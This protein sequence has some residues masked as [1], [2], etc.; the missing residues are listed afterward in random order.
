MSLQKNMKYLDCARVRGFLTWN[1]ER[2]E[3]IRL[4]FR[5]KRRI[6]RNENAGLT[7]INNFDGKKEKT[8]LGWNWLTRLE[9]ANGIRNNQDSSQNSLVIKTLQTAGS[10]TVNI[11]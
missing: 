10:T 3:K 7:G 9:E 5:K 6:L 2:K 4:K 8:S 11:L 1:G